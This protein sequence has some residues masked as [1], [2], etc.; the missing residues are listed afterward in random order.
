MTAADDLVSR[1][2]AMMNDLARRAICG[3]SSSQ[4]SEKLPPEFGRAGASFVTLHRAGSLRG[5]CG[6]VSARRPLVEDIK[7]NAV[8]SAFSDPRFAPL[9]RLEWGTLSLTVTL[10]SPLEPMRFEGEA[11]L[12]SQLQPH[13]DGLLIEDAGRQAIF[14][15]AVWEMLNEKEEFLAHLKAKAG[16]AQGHWSPAF[17][18]SRFSTAQ[19]AAEPLLC[20]ASEKMPEIA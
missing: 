4:P 15:P 13:R 16:L 3:E 19:S 10:L 14:L 1:H 11:D 12:L 20:R 7:A 9:Q 18:A 6:S 17:R 5:C 8:R 2:G